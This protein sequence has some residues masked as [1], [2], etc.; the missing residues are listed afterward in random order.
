M[1]LSPGLPAYWS[2]QLKVPVA[3]R[4]IHLLNVCHVLPK[5]VL[6]LFI[7]GTDEIVNCFNSK[8]W[9]ALMGVSLLR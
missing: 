3:K 8:G 5:L 1:Q 2:S 4:A 6:L 7:Y 9:P